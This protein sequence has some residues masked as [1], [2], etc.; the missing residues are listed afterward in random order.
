MLEESA[1]AWKG[2]ERGETSDEGQERLGDGELEETYRG[3]EWKTVKKES[4]PS[5]R[6]HEKSD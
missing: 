2:A 6:L 1:V 3:E 5:V 4:V